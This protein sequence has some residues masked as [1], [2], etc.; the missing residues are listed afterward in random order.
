MCY[1]S[2]DDDL[3]I[4]SS[5]SR[6]G[7]FQGA[8]MNLDKNGKP[9][10]SWLNPAM[11]EMLENETVRKLQDAESKHAFLANECY[12]KAI[13]Q[14]KQDKKIYCDAKFKSCKNNQCF[15]YESNKD[16]HSLIIEL[17]EQLHQELKVIQ[18]SLTK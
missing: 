11:E 2:D 15:F 7:K 3:D 6:K 12:K 4:K 10:P 1:D 8:V 17:R 13:V 14:T 16:I 18:A 9:I 5:G